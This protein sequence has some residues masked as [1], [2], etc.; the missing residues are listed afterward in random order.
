ML[1]LLEVKTGDN[2][3]EVGCGRGRI[4]AHMADAGNCKVSGVN[5][6]ATQV[7]QVYLN[8]IPLVFVIVK[9]HLVSFRNNQS[10]VCQ[11]FIFK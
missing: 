11:A 8:W 5:I 9:V 2:V 6:D 4:A 10:L 7:S 1:E 3:L